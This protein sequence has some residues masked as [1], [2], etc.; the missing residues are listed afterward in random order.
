MAML[1]VLTAAIALGYM[2]SLWWLLRRESAPVLLAV[3]VLCGL[4]LCLRLAY[5]TNFPTGLSEDEV[6]TLAYAVQDFRGGHALN[7]GPEGPLLLDVLFQAPLVPIVGPNRWAIRTYAM[8]S[9]VLSV[10]LAFAVGRGLGLRIA[11]SLGIGALVAVLPWSIFYGRISLGGEMTFHQLLLIAAVV[12]LVWGGGG[13]A[14]VGIGG[15]G[16][17]LLLYDY[18]AGLSMLAIAPLAAVL[19]RGRR[20]IMCVAI[21]ILAVVAWAPYLQG[22]GAD[23]WKQQITGKVPVSFEEQF[24]VTLQQKISG[25]L[26]ALIYPSGRDAW[27]TIRSAAMHPPIILIL[28]VLGSFTGVRRALFF[29]PAFLAAMSP[30]VFSEG[31]IPSTHRMLMMFPFIAIAAGCALNAVRWRW[32]RGA[33]TVATV[34][35]AAVQSIALYFSPSFWPP[36][37]LGVFDWE[38]TAVMEALPAGSRSRLIVAPDMDPF[39]GLLGTVDTNY[40]FLGV[41]NWFPSDRV[42]SIY[43]F[44]SANN[45]LLAFYEQLLGS[46][47]VQSFGR[48][49]VVNIEAGNWS[50]LRQHG[51]MY[52]VRCGTQVKQGLVPTLHHISLS[53]RTFSCNG[54]ATHIWRGRWMGPPA[55]LRLRFSGSVTVDSSRGRLVEKEGRETNQDFNVDQGT[56]LT[57]TLTPAGTGPVA[58]LQVTPAGERLPAWEWVDPIE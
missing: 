4:S 34:L 1:L 22:P 57:V 27:L 56:E 50:W 38:R 48:A 43:A 52:E 10:A 2:A 36:D 17:A 32:A 29:W 47:R 9:S 28:A 44:G 14:E 45:A 35:V 30:S 5:T 51:W 21:L 33:I 40:E 12:R 54:A 46:R 31:S 3:L 15:L 58:V 55:Q 37:S 49:F 8:L 11:P 23:S 25:N 20:R 16:L 7:L 42:D 53:F 41:E 19:A 13:G 6:K 26:H 24:S 39:I 18:T